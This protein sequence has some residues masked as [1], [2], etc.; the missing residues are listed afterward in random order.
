[1][2][3]V[4]ECWR[5]GEPGESSSTINAPCTLIY[6]G[7]AV[8]PIASWMATEVWFPHTLTEPGRS[9]VPALRRFVFIYGNE[10]TATDGETVAGGNPGGCDS[11]FDI[12]DIEYRVKQYDVEIEI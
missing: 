8:S 6:E 2:S 1:M 5:G 4:S 3:L 10:G 12:F 7:Y 11:I 9:K